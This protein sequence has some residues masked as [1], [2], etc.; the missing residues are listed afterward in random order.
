MNILPNPAQHYQLID[1]NKHDYNKSEGRN[2]IYPNHDNI[3]ED[4]LN[5]RLSQLPVS[6]TVFGRATLPGA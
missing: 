2:L 6:P 1:I 3:R 5:T 4:N